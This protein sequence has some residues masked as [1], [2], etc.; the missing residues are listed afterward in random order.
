MHNGNALKAVWMAI[1]DEFRDQSTFKKPR[2]A[3]DLEEVSVLYLTPISNIGTPQGVT[4]PCK[5]AQ[6]RA[7][8]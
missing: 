3:L 4:L 2:M 6:A 1:F 5:M 7:M 8:G